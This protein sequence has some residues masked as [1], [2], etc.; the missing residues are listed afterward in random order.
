MDYS[1]WKMIWLKIFISNI[2][3]G[4]SL[5][6]FSDYKMEHMLSWQPVPHSFRRAIT[7]RTYSRSGSHSRTH[8]F[9]PRLERCT[10]ISILVQYS[11]VQSQFYV[12]KRL[13]RLT[14]SIHVKVEC[15]ICISNL[16]VIT[17][18]IEP[19]LTFPSWGVCHFIW[20]GTP[21]AQNTLL[22][23]PHAGFD[24]AIEFLNPVAKKKVVCWCHAQYLLL[25]KSIKSPTLERRRQRWLHTWTYKW[26]LML[27]HSLSLSLSLS[28]PFFV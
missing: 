10:A 19:W 23:Y 20:Q 11:T 21:W 17:V 9:S 5:L 15:H 26:I 14:F 28:Q 16:D 6:S 8:S 27:S 18:V 4:R 2:P 3:L 22:S 7:A 12:C 1:A 24:A 25:S 13:V